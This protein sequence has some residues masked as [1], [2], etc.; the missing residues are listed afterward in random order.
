MIKKL[1]NIKLLFVFIQIIGFIGLFQHVHIARAEAL[2][3]SGVLEIDYTGS[4]GPLF[5]A[6]NLAPGYTETKSLSVKNNGSLPHSFSIAVSGDLGVLADVLIIEPKV[7]GNVVWSKTISQIAKNPESNVIIGSIVAGESIF[8]DITARLPETI[9]NEYQ[10][11]STLAFN[12]I[13]GNESTDESE[14][15]NEESSDRQGV[16]QR[17]INSVRTALQ[18]SDTDSNKENENQDKQMQDDGTVSGVS[19]VGESLGEQTENKPVCFWWWLLIIVLIIFLV[20]YGYYI[21]KNRTIFAWVWPIFSG[22]VL[23][24]VHWIMH[25]YY[26]PSRWCHYFPYGEIIIFFV[27]YLIQYFYQQKNIEEK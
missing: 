10:G 26:T 25:S 18:A 16:I 4:P 19:K 23:Y 12:F 14:F 17:T 13:V 5:N 11:K 8:V 21:R 24:A 1:L 7:S 6:S 15:S 27:Y 9:G 20:I 2:N 22:G 3:V